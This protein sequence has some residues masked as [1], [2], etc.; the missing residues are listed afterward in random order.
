M[1]ELGD[2]EITTELHGKVV[3]I[4]EPTF[5]LHVFESAPVTAFCISADIRYCCGS[6]RNIALCAAQGMHF[7]HTNRIVHLD[8]KSA[9]VLLSRD[10]SVAK[11][12]DVGL[13]RTLNT[14]CDPRTLLPQQSLPAEG[15]A[16]ACLSSPSANASCC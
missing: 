6:G 7:L 12:A 8:L 10:G 9:N 15:H 13:A 4:L 11:L 5:K 3:F 14:Q 1:C 2:G 16:H